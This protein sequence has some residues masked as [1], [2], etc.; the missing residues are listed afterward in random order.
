MDR[1]DIEIALDYWRDVLTQLRKAYVAL[2]GGG[3]KSYTI[4]DRQLTKFDLG[5]LRG[6][7]D[8]AEKKVE[9]LSALLSGQRPRKG[10][11][12]LPRDW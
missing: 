9:E 12:V 3:V 11:A 2:I 6:E 4:D 1:K 5:T 8:Q 10:F 7:I